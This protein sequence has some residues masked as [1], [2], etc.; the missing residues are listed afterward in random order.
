MPGLS[1]LLAL[2]TTEARLIELAA[3][4]SLALVLAEILW[5][6]TTGLVRLVWTDLSKARDEINKLNNS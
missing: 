6:K 5:K 3:L 2:S 4:L 1:F